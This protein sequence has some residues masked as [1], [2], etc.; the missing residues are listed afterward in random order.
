MNQT[1]I[2]ITNGRSVCGQNS[3]RR[4]WDDSKTFHYV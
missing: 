4:M 2:S 1:D 3:W